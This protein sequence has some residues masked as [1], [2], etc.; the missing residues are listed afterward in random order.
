VRRVASA[1]GTEALHFAEPVVWLRGDKELAVVR[2]SIVETDLARVSLEGETR[3]VAGVDASSGFAY[4]PDGTRLAYLRSYQR[5]L[6]ITRPGQDNVTVAQRR[7]RSF[8]G[9]ITWSP[10]GRKLALFVDVHDTE[11]KE[12]AVIDADGS[13]LR[14]VGQTLPYDVVGAAV[15]RPVRD[16]QGSR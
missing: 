16:S 12:V 11:K 8:S 15:W 14:T 2:Q 7:G 6:V 9:P 13:G 3:P 5:N 4:S 1:K 10:D